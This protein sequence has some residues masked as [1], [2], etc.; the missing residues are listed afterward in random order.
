MQVAHQIRLEIPSAAEYVGVVRQAIEG[1]ASRMRFDPT[2]VED[3]KLAVGEACNNAVKHGCPSNLH[4]CITV[5]CK[6]TPGVLE[7]EISNGLAGGE[8]RPITEGSPDYSQEGGMG[9]Y[10][11]QRVMDEVEIVWGDQMAKIR[12]VKRLKP[13]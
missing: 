9:L 4:P 12:M 10:I 13:Y 3:L 7:I 2:D 5:V 11:M 1:I 8:P 6:V